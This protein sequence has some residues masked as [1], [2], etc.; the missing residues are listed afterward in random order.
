MSE[1]LPHGAKGKNFLYNTSL[2]P[3]DRYIDSVSYFGKLKKIEL[4]SKALRENLNGNFGQAER[5]SLVL[6]RR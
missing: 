2:E 1:A 3:L 5:R 6:L 4:Y